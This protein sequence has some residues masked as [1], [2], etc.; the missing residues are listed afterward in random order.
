MSWTESVSQRLSISAVAIYSAVFSIELGFF[1][2]FD[3]FL[4]LNFRPL[5]RTK[6]RVR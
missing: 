6:M 1:G 2:I 3:A 5:L 4:G